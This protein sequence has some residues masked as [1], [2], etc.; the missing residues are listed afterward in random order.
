MAI[1]DEKDFTHIARTT[2]QWENARDKYEIIPEGVLC[3]EFSPSNITKIKIGDGHKY[4]SQLPYIGNGDLNNYYTKR[5]T[6]DRVLQIMLDN[7]S[8]R[9]KGELDSETKLPTHAACGDVWFVKSTTESDPKNRYIEYIYSHEHKWEIIGGTPIDI[10]LSGYAKKEYVD[11]KI[12]VVNK[13]IDSFDHHTHDNKII[14]DQI[15]AFFTSEEKLKLKELHNYDDTA[16][17]ELIEQATHNHPNKVILDKITAAYTVADKSKLDG[18]S[19]YDDTLLIAKITALEELAHEHL[20]KTIL[21]NTTASF[22]K[23]YEKKLKWIRVYTGATDNEDGIMGMVPP[24]P[25]GDQDYVLNGAGEWVPMQGGSGPIDPATKTKTGVVKIGDGISVKADGTISILPPDE[26]Q[27]GGI[28]PGVGLTTDRFGKLDIIYGEGLGI[29]DDGK[30]YATGEK[31]EPFRYHPGN[32]ITFEIEDP[33]EKDHDITIN[34]TIATDEECGVVIIGD[35]LSITEDGIVSVKIGNGLSLDEETGEINIDIATYD[36]PGIVKPGKGLTISEDGTLDVTV[37]APDNYHPGKG[38]YFTTVDETYH[39]VTYIETDGI[40]KVIDTDVLPAPD[41]E[42]H[43]QFSFIEPTPNTYISGVDNDTNGGFTVGT[44][45]GITLITNDV[46]TIPDDTISPNEIMETSINLTSEHVLSDTIPL[47]ARS[48]NGTYDGFAKMRLYS[49]F[50]VSNNE[51]VNVGLVPVVRDS[52]NKPGLFNLAT[53]DFLTNAIPGGGDFVAGELTDKLYPMTHGDDKYINIYPASNYSIGGVI[54]RNGLSVDEKGFL[55][56]SIGDTLYIDESGRI[57]VKEVPDKKKYSEGTGI[58]ITQDPEDEDNNIITN[59][60]ILDVTE[61]EEDNQIIVSTKDG[62]KV[63]NITPSIDE[64]PIATKDTLGG[65]IVGDNLTIDEDGKLSAISS[66]SSTNI[67]FE[68]GPGIDINSSADSYK[69]L[70]YIQSDG[71]QTIETDIIMNSNNVRVECKYKYD[72]FDETNQIVFFVG[73]SSIPGSYGYGL[74]N[75]K[76]TGN[77]NRIS[78]WTATNANNFQ[79][80]HG[81]GTLDV[82]TDTVTFTSMRAHSTAYA[83]DSTEPSVYGMATG[84]KLY[85]FGRQSLTATDGTTGEAKLK[86][87]SFKLYADDELIADFAPAIRAS[88]NK[89]GLFNRTNKKFYVNTRSDDDFIPGNLTG[90]IIEI[91]TDTKTVTISNTGILDV[92]ESDEKNQFIIT[93]KDGD[94]PINISVEG[95]GGGGTEY[96]A[97][98]AISIT[99]HHSGLPPIPEGYQPIEYI[100]SDGQQYIDTGYKPRHNSHIKMRISCNDNASS[101]WI[102]LLGSRESGSGTGANSQVVFITRNYTLGPIAE[103]WLGSTDKASSP[104][105]PYETIVDVEIKSNYLKWTNVETGDT[106]TLTNSIS[107]MDTD[108]SL[109]L[110]SLN[111]GGYEERLRSSSTVYSLKI[112]EDDILVHDF[113]PVIEKATLKVGLYDAIDNKFVSSLSSIELINGPAIIGDGDVISVKY[114]SG[115]SLDDEGNLQV[116]ELE[117]PIATKDALGGIKVG[118]GLE[119]DPATGILSATGGGGSKD[120]TVSAGEGI[121]VQTKSFDPTAEYHRISYIRNNQDSYIII[122]DYIANSSTRVV[123]EYAHNPGVYRSDGAL[124]GAKSSSYGYSWYSYWRSGYDYFTGGFQYGSNSTAL[125]NVSGYPQGTKMLLDVSTRGVY[126]NNELIQ[127]VVEKGSLPT[128]PMSIFAASSTNTGTSTIYKP[129]AFTIYSFKI[130]EGEDLVKDLVPALNSEMVPGLWDLVNG[131]FYGSANTN[132]FAY[133][134]T[135][136]DMDKGT[137]IVSSSPA[138]LTTIGGI[139]PGEGLKVEDDGTL[140][141]SETIISE[142]DIDFKTDEGLLIHDVPDHGDIVLPTGYKS[143][144]YVESRA[145]ASMTLDYIP[146]SNTRISIDVSF[147]QGSSGLTKDSGAIIGDGSPSTDSVPKYT[148]WAAWTNSMTS[149]L[150]RLSNGT[151]NRNDVPGTDLLNYYDHKRVTFDIIPMDGLYADGEKLQDWEGGEFEPGTKQ[152]QINR[153]SS[154]TTYGLRIY[155]IKIW[156]KGVLLLNL[157]PV[158]DPSNVSGLYDTIRRKFFKTTSTANYL[159]DETSVDVI[160]VEKTLTLLPATKTFI[161]GVRIG[162][163]LSVDDDGTI[164]VTGGGGGGYANI[165][166]GNGLTMSGRSSITYE[167]LDFVQTNGHQSVLTDLYPSLTK[168]T[169]EVKYEFLNT[170][171]DNVV[172]STGRAFGSGELMYGILNTTGWHLC[173]ALGMGSRYDF[174]ETTVPTGVVEDTYTVIDRSSYGSTLTGTKSHSMTLAN[175]SPIQLFKVNNWSTLASVKLYSMNVFNDDTLVGELVP[176]RNRATKMVG[177]L[178]KTTNM[179]YV[180]DTENM[181]IAGEPT[182]ET[183]VVGT[184]QKQIIKAK[185]GNGLKFDEK[186]AIALEETNDD[187]DGDNIVVGEVDLATDPGLRIYNKSASGSVALPKGYSSISYIEPMSA[188]YIELDYYPNNTTRTIVRTAFTLGLSDDAAI[189][190]SR[191]RTGSYYVFWIHYESGSPSFRFENG[192]QGWSSISPVII[193]DYTPYKIIEI[194][195]NPANGE[196]CIDGVKLQNCTGGTF[197]SD[198]KLHLFAINGYNHAAEPTRIYSTKIYENNELKLDL[199]PALNEE[200]EAGMYDGVNEKFYKAKQGSFSYDEST[201][202]PAGESTRTIALLPA[203]TDTIGGVIVGNG[204]SIDENGKLNVIRQSD[205]DQDETNYVT[206]VIAKEGEKGVLKVTHKVPDTDTEVDLYKALGALVIN[207]VADE[208]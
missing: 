48:M 7:C 195:A 189:F 42:M 100:K 9:I 28:T 140:N 108:Y 124:F 53:G 176:A 208:E 103:Y 26:E 91:G 148:L 4:F 29:D 206:D 43:I 77:L 23:E 18:L 202:T 130:Y 117:I 143:I 19:N 197:I 128:Y 93:T 46:I 115:L 106:D 207:C 69:V 49:A 110:F 129:G 164:N 35:G 163:G 75:W 74:Y 199:V 120:L 166:V 138:T 64:I 14:L 159:Y 81:Q 52:D 201:I 109:Y 188:A 139:K 58:S 32:A 190:G 161:G 80:A 133:D 194:D 172:F 57:E 33:E 83:L 76:S 111:N 68:E 187:E 105:F 158:L 47:F 41:M 27:I 177:I 40:D 178:N 72:L 137:Y 63:I 22:T 45:D 179:F 153:S 31:E 146:S 37:Q 34:A 104:T 162:D 181:L 152:I 60:G 200:N 123:V 66:G 11:E 5:E 196:V 54:V 84:E 70:D 147:K 182:G 183:V 82:I 173:S 144:S 135:S 38:V 204:L 36:T 141:V 15:T 2:T 192:T 30:L 156:D 96:I 101:G 136:I 94:K 160:T 116:D 24:A 87:W 132:S 21:D 62:D 97:G 88:D 119:I 99:K 71:N 165:E 89:P 157:V 50:I 171:N 121:N 78:L 185:L 203:T 175:S 85:L 170:S 102:S 167:I 3:V 112:Y 17:R 122:P 145:N 1:A 191:G 174:L 127:S 180:S 205:S 142:V 125:V 149:P 8:V 13:K 10:D 56:V 16:L 113:V 73:L 92:K 169:V 126:L 131:V 51:V 59:T 20:N 98:D 107:I 193:S 198:A 118:N 65:I 168:T 55:D 151:V 67:I 134:S 155:S 184:D 61:S 186:G 6:D 79:L 39:G 44:N 154:Y 25:A 95:G 114:G 86:M 12:N 90:E 150:I